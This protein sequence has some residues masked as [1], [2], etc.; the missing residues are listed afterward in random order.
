[1]GCVCEWVYVSDVGWHDGMGLMRSVI[2]TEKHSYRPY[3]H[4]LIDSN[5]IFK[6]EHHHHH[7]QHHHHQRHQGH[8]RIPHTYLVNIRRRCCCCSDAPGRLAEGWWWLGVGTGTECRICMDN[9]NLIMWNGTWRRT[10]KTF[11]SRENEYV[12]MFS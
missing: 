5:M 11:Q 10:R 1:M 4:S 6:Q 8:H 12:R 7:N 2:R 3:V 9:V